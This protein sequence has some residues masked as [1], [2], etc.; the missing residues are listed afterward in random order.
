LCQVQFVP[1]LQK[2]FKNRRALI[3]IGEHCGTGYCSYLFSNTSTVTGT[4][5]GR[6]VGIR[7]S[8]FWGTGLLESRGQDEKGCPAAGDS[9]K[10]E[11]RQDAG[12]GRLG[13]GAGEWGR[14]FLRLSNVSRL[15]QISVRWGS[16]ESW[17]RF[18]FESPPKQE[19]VRW[20]RGEAWAHDST[21][22]LQ[23]KE[24]GR[25]LSRRIP[26]LVVFTFPV[27][28]EPT[29]LFTGSTARRALLWPA[30]SRT[31]DGQ[32]NP[33]HRFWPS[34]QHAWLRSVGYAS[35]LSGRQARTMRTKVLDLPEP[36]CAR[37]D[38]RR[39]IEHRFHREMIYNIPSIP[40]CSACEV[41]TVN[42]LDALP[43]KEIWLAD[44]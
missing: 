9:R 40:S 44:F 26:S 30:D 5:H 23:L 35:K 28:L 8:R 11:E 16:K 42:A 22:I 14:R 12:A 18:R 24:R 10:Q 1:T 37:S 29:W 36:A 3:K 13:G 41:P 27:E 31:R 39:D 32:H 38:V 25:D 17:S 20:R 7:N 43:F 21:C 2:P 34:R 6:A 19:W 33:W 4:G 15:S